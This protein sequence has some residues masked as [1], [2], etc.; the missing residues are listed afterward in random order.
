MTDEIRDA[1]K[2]LKDVECG[3]A[4]DRKALDSVIAYIEAGEKEMPER[5]KHVVLITKEGK[6]ARTVDDWEKK[7][8]NAALDACA[9]II[10]RLTSERDA[11]QAKIDAVIK[12]AKT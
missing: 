3:Y 5:K 2:F 8:F 1:I 7:G 10:A 9:P 11:L 12:M 6:E 4:P